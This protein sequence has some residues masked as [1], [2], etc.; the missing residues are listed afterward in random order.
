[1][2][3]FTITFLSLFTVAG[4]RLW[5]YRLL[6]LCL[7]AGLVAAVGL[8]A[9]IP[10]YA[11]AAHNRLLQGE[12]TETGARRPPFAFLWRYVGAW[13]GDVAWDSY[14]PL[15]EY[16][17]QQAAG[18]IGLPLEA[19]V[20]HVSTAK[21]RLFPA[22]EGVFTSDEPLLWASAGFISGLQDHIQLVEGRFPESQEDSAGALEV[23]VSRETAGQ[24]GLQVGEEYV[25]FAAG[26]EG[27]QIPVRIAGVW[28]ATDP[29]DPFW[30]Y[31]P[32][33]FS[34][35]LLTSEE[36]F[37]HQ[38]VPALETP[39]ATA[40]WYQVFDGSRVRPASV[41]ALLEGV[42]VVEAR[43][44]ALL[45]N[46][47]LD[48]SPVAALGDYGRAARL[49]TLTLTVFSLPVVG[50][51]LYFISLVAGMV[52]SRGQGEIAVLRSRGAT[53]W[54]ILG[55]YALEG[56]LIGGMGL[57]GGLLLGE[58]LAQLMGRAR[59]FLD[60]ALLAGDNAG[61]LVTV[62]SPTALGYGL[63]GVALAL[64]ALLIP[65][66]ASAG[67]TIVTLRWQQAR[68]LLAP[69]WQ[70]YF[71]D[72]F[73]LLPPLYGWYQLD[74]QGAIGLLDRGNDPFTNPLLFLVPALFCFALGLFLV[75]LFPWLM[76]GL[77]WLAAWLPG[78]TPL[79][80]LRQLA[81][82]AVLYTGP[83]LL[84]TLTVSLATFTASMAVTLNDHLAEWVYYQVGADLNLAELGENTEES[85][86]PALPGQEQFADDAASD[87]EEPR[88]LFLPVTDHL[89]VPGV[90]AAARVGD[91]SATANI[92]GRQQSGHLLGVDRADFTAVAY[93]RPDFAANESLGGLMNRLAVRRDHIL[94]SRDFLDRHGLQVGDSLRLT[95]GA[96]DEFADVEFT[97]AGALDLF[98]TQYPQEGPFFVANLDYIHEGLGGTFPYNVWLATDPTVPS[99][100]IVDGVRELGLV[101]VTAA[102]ARATIAAEQNRPERQGLFGL[103]SVG[104]LAA[105]GL[106]VL[107]FLVYTVVSFRR[108]FIELGMLRAVG[109]SL[110]Q[111]AVYL[112]GEQTLLILAGTGLGTA[113]GVLV[114]ALFIPYFQ[115][116]AGKTAQVP[117]FVVQIAWGQLETIYTLFALMFIVALMALVALLVRMKL[118]EAV[119]LGEA[120]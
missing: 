19:Q 94:V 107:G 76:R 45:N 66:F 35:V 96:A 43:V 65:A 97:I 54:Q 9:S 7:L 58:R 108:R 98:P 22:G 29:A 83:L 101:V 75:R 26:Q 114:S 31:Q 73:L 89:R 40:V 18:V 68:A 15:D 93:Y 69:L 71:L 24:L 25:L 30:F 103:L 80:V 21:L 82:S 77:A 1:M 74:R 79:L 113:L 41:S 112:A 5:N 10:L 92:G 88:W 106:T 34:E 33:A 13:H 62:L 37:V 104:F 102:D 46:A 47:T 2:T 115:V 85:E 27:A 117:P 78:V 48:V 8:L 50:L 84:L 87:E 55:V 3:R 57:V 23:M 86:Q 99:D 38:V 16:L 59:T 116:G 36:A 120:V 20:R 70:R 90:K 67:Y 56:A 14:T 61:P 95:V 11:D 4:R 17:T 111:M 91:Y 100:S 32:E 109:L 81:R 119:K 51:V 60:P 39:V 53:R 52:V 44:T 12:L 6:M 110:G 118:F 72:F 63:L 28:Q 64:L 105:A 42:A 49:L